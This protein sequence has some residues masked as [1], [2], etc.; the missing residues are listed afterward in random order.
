[1]SDLAQGRTGM[2][3]MKLLEQRAEQLAGRG[4]T[5]PSPQGPRQ[6]PVCEG[7]GVALRLGLKDQ[8]EALRR[9]HRRWGPPGLAEQCG[10]R[11][12]QGNNLPGRAG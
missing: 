12:P 5:G 6:D 1:M 3:D 9:R 10:P 2:D 4:Q 11:L 7:E 8:A